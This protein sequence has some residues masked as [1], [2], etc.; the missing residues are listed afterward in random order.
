MSFPPE[1]EEEN[2]RVTLRAIGG[3]ALLQHTASHCDLVLVLFSSQS[4][5]QILNAA[6]HAPT[7]AASGGGRLEWDGVIL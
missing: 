7:L 4:A 1:A 6:P 2:R 3:I 5:K